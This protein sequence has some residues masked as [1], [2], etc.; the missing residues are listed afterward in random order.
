MRR[1][2]RVANIIED[3]KLAGPQVRMANVSCAL[4]DKVETVVILPKENSEKFIDRLNLCNIPYKT[5]SLSRIT[6]ELKVALS[7]VFFSVFEIFNL[8]SYFRKQCFDLIHASGGSWQYK[9]IIAGKAAGIKVVWHLNDTSMPWLL[10]MIFS[11]LSRFSDAYIFASERTRSY[12][13]PLI[14]NKKPQYVIPAPVNVEHFSPKINVNIDNIDAELIA[15]CEGKTVLGTVANINPIKGLDIFIRVAAIL[16]KS[17]NN[18]QFLVIGPI[19]NNQF[20]HYEYLKSLMIELGVNNIK[21]VGS[22]DELRPLL[23]RINVYL[24]TSYAESSP[25]S[26]WEAMS[27]GKPIVSTDVGDVGKYISLG[28]SGEIVPVGNSELMAIKIQEIF[29]NKVKMKEYGENSREIAVQ[30]LGLN[31]CADSHYSAY[32][33]II[34]K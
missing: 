1:V 10:R 27:M 11:R 28:G 20:K 23:N 29:S 24:C 12:Y 26:V 16:N 13:S 25:I 14:K 34:D 31:K 15:Q 30:H 3:G 18:L 2:I 7:Y 4:K 5:F 9:G 6:K 19:W 21:F 22:R 32:L 33:D 17:N 8:T